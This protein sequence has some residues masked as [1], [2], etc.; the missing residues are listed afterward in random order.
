MTNKKK[1]IHFVDAAKRPNLKYSV[2]SRCVFRLFRLHRAPYAGMW[3]ENKIKYPNEPI[4][5]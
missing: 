4:Q 2:L 1:A 5:N 3:E